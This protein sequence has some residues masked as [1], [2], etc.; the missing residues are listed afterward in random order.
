[1]T[2]KGREPAKPRNGGAQAALPFYRNPPLAETVLAVQFDAISSLSDAYL[3][4]FWKSLGA[5]WTKI[6]QAPPLGQL[7]EPREDVGVAPDALRLGI[8]TDLGSRFRI[9]GD[10][11]D[12]MVQIENGWFVYNWR[13]T[14]NTTEYPR[15][16]PVRSE[17]IALLDEFRRFLR[18][19]FDK[20]VAPNLW[21]VTYINVIA[22]GPLWNT[23]GDWS[24]VS[25]V[26]FP[27]PATPHSVSFEGLAGHWR[28]ALPK[29]SGRLHVHAA[30]SVT[31]DLVVRLTARG[32]IDGDEL[33]EQCW[34]GFDIG[35][36]AIVNSFT[37]LTSPEAHAFW[38]RE[39]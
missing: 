3:G 10:D 32:S 2:P 21:E 17:F 5:P 38:G 18:K 30:Q 39:R 13:R 23:P 15:F 6:H 26:L 31:G 27:K 16:E 24:H 34:K 36:A 7:V 19:E 28:Y 22:S 4:V 11:N 37:E 9:T 25:P 1:V 8:S 33:W 20:D 35:H 29:G 12:R 14:K